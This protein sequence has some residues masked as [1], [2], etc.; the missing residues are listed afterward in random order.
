MKLEIKKENIIKDLTSWFRYAEPEGGESQWE[1][2]RSA[3]EFAR[4]M[5]SSK[6]QLPTE[7]QKYLSSIGFDKEDYLCMPEEVTSYDDYDLGN[8]SGR[9]H[10]GLLVSDHH[11]I[12]IEA[13][14]SESFDNSVSKKMEAAK[15]NSGGG[16][17]MRKRIFNSLK[18]IK[19]DFDDNSLE[20]VGDLMYQLI[21]GMIGT[22]IEANKRKKDKAVF[23]IIEFSGDVKK[24]KSYANNVRRNHESYDYF[25]RFLGLNDKND[26]DRYIITSGGKLR[27]WIHKLSI[28]VHRK[29]YQYNQTT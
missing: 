20:S 13:K 24:E 14:V 7:I 26:I 21:S 12:G 27:V 16:K 8:G 22:I 28:E 19:E 4:Y 2:G 6:G 3:M 5:T 15:K 23:L 1:E 18:M 11:I 29:N 10:D 9:H 17:N 25:L